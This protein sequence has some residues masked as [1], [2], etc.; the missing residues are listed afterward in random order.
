[1]E[2]RCKPNGESVTDDHSDLLLDFN[3][4]FICRVSFIWSRFGCSAEIFS[5][6]HF[7]GCVVLQDRLEEQEREMK[8]KYDSKEAKAANLQKKISDLEDKLRKKEAEIRKIEVRV[9][10]F[11]VCLNPK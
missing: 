3:T 8:K 10:K 9:R 4:R 7:L 11:L 5:S 1:M 6:T 2:T